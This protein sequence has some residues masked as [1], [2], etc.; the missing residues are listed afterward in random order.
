MYYKLSFS[1]FVWNL[2]AQNISKSKKSSFNFTIGEQIK[3]Q[4]I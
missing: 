1:I 3:N 2:N 4:I